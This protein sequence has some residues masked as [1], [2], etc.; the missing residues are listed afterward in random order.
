MT[1]QIRI[2]INPDTG[3]DYEIN[4]PASEVVRE[5]ILALEFPPEGIRVVH[6]TERLAEQFELSDEQKHAK[7]RSGLNVFRYDV[8]APQFKRLLQEGELIQPGGPR[9]PYFLAVGDAELR[10]TPSQP[11]WESVARMAADRDTGEEYQIQ[12]PATRIVKQALL[13]FDYPPSGIRIRDIAEALADQFV[14]TEEQR[15]AGGKYGP[16]WKRH[17]N[18]TSAGLVKSGQLLRISRGW[19][20]NPERYSK[21][22]P[23]GTKSFDRSYD[24]FISHATEDKDE[25]VRPLAEALDKRGVCVWYD[26]FELRIGDS[27]RGKIEKGLANSRYGIV[28]LS[29]AFFQKKKN[30][31]QYE[32][33]ALVAKET[34]DEPL[35]FPIWHKITKDEIAS[36]SP[37]LIDKIALKTSDFTIDE[38]AK[39]IAER[40]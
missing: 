9:T 24:A 4:L 27:L 38:I 12:L 15:E 17:V 31:P 32:L 20:T 23:S 8:V 19:I 25:I 16:V 22:S 37:G 26:E 7:N 3:K 10:E 21:L 30:W 13:N 33:N 29:H 14:L 34:A 5:A 39:K 1:N 11:E 40:I 28:V 2:A 36:H 18:I 6:A 35:I